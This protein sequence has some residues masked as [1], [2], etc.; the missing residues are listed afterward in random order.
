MRRLK[1]LFPDWLVLETREERLRRLTREDVARTFGLCPICSRLPKQHR[2]FDLAVTT[3]G[4]DEDDS[5]TRLAA[6]HDWF[7]LNQFNE[8]DMQADLHVW[9]VLS[10]PK[11]RSVIGW[12]L[13]HYEYSLRDRL[14]QVVELSDADIRAIAE[15]AK[16]RWREV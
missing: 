5:A 15:I 4:T 3:V 6:A 7:A 2:Y 11:G 14:L 1:K 8:A 13:S 10:C 9:R 12:I 16:D